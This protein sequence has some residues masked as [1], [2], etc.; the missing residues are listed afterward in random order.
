MYTKNIFDKGEKEQ[1]MGRIQSLHSG[2]E[3][4]WGKMDASQM[5]AHLQIS[6]AVALGQ[7]QVQENRLLKTILSLFKSVLYNNRPMKKNLPTGRPFITSN[8]ARI[9]EEEKQKLLTLLT[10]FSPEMIQNPN[11]PFFGKLTHEQ[12]G[13]AVWKHIDHHLRQFSA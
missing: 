12:W 6:I 1:V 2:Q 4:L 13:K 8:N 7:M 9:F 11:Y 5:L 3:R 10:R